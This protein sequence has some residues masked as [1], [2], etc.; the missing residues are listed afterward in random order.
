MTKA[1]PKGPTSSYHHLWGLEFQ[2]MSLWRTQTFRPQQVLRTEMRKAD[3]VLQAQVR[4]GGGLYWGIGREKLMD[5][6]YIIGRE[7]RSL[8]NPPGPGIPKS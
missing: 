2:H 4:D 5:Q 6:R 3:N 8:N 7:I 1:L